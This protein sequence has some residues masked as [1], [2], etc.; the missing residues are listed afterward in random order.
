MARLRATVHSD[1]ASLRRARGLTQRELARI[2]GVSRQTIVEIE[3][4]GYNPSV[5]LALRLGVVLAAPVERLFSLPAEDLA[6]LRARAGQAASDAG[7]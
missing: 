3:A 4:G 2:A 6:A 5:A 1:V 7:G